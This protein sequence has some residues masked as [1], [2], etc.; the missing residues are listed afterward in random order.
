MLGS[1]K[2]V[3][4][5]SPGETRHAFPAESSPH[6]QIRI[7]S[8]PKDPEVKAHRGKGPHLKPH[9]RDVQEPGPV[10]GSGHST[11]SS[12]R[13]PSWPGCSGSCIEE[14]RLRFGWSVRLHCNSNYVIFQTPA[15]DQ[16]CGKRSS[17]GKNPVW[18]KLSCTHAL[19][20][21]QKTRQ[22]LT[23]LTHQQ[24]CFMITTFALPWTLLLTVT[25][26]G[27]W[28]Y[29][30]S[31]HCLKWPDPSQLEPWCGEH[32]GVRPFQTWDRS[33]TKTL[34]RTFSFLRGTKHMGVITY[35]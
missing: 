30:P 22:D 9:S 1:S 3:G 14:P 5:G 35:N 12:E 8:G 16:M 29:V 34:F 13:F 33:F 11:Y 27:S 7:K 23:T 4:C 17:W 32:S 20:Q 26:R 25:H 24:T 21:A 19:Q 6:S 28:G 2:R 10:C 18:Q 31:R 15:H